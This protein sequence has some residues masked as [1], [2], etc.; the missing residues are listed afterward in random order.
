[1]TNEEPRFTVE[2]FVSLMKQYEQENWGRTG[3][4]HGFNWWMEEFS[5]WLKKHDFEESTVWVI[6]K[7]EADG[8]R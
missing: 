2:Q 8:K 1:M 6:K 7:K 4:T 3:A 5:G